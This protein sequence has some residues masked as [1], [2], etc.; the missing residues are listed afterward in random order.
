MPLKSG[1]KAR[2]HYTGTL[3][4][5]TVFDSSR[6][7]DPLEFTLGK[8]MLL[9]GFEAAVEGREPGETVTVT[10]PSEQA[11]GEMDPELVFTVARMQ[12]PGHIPLEVGTAL[13]LSNEQGQMDVVITEVGEDDVT[14]DANH[15]LAGKDLAFEIE[16]LS[17]D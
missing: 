8:G 2:I 1:D 3:P 17:A 12:V 6:G 15:P 5:G 16:I 7:R 11:Y 14:L 10:I 13:Q 4:D 9:P